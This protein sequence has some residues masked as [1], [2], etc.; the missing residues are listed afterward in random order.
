MLIETDGVFTNHFQTA[1]D[2]DSLVTINMD[3]E[4]TPEFH[5]QG[6]WW[7]VG[8]SLT[9]FTIQEYQVADFPRDAEF[10]TTWELNCP[11]WQFE[12]YG[13]HNACCKIIISTFENDSIELKATTANRC[14]TIT[15]SKWIHCTYFNTDDYQDLC[16]VDIVPNPNNGNMTLKFENMLGEVNV[17]VYNATG[18]LVDNFDCNNNFSTMSMQY[19]MKTYVT[20]MYYFVISSKDRMIA[21]KVI[22]K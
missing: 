16:Y 1:H 22:V 3:M 20:G 11:N 14:D 19:T 17:K 7:P 4:Y 15:R 2:C 21:K 5:L 10:N 9:H 6:D 13:E 18:S 8:G 12:T